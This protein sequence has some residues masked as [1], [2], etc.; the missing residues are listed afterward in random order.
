MLRIAVLGLGSIGR[1]HVRN[2]IA[3]GAGDLLGFD[4][5]AGAAGL[6][7]RE[8][9]IRTVT[10]LDEV[11]AFAPSAVFVTSPSHHHVPLALDA[12]R[13]GCDLFI[14]KPLSDS[15]DAIDQL[16]LAA[17]SQRLVTMVGCNM[18]FHPGPAAV[19]RLIQEGA[20]GAVLSARIH[21]GSYLPDWRPG[22]RYQDSYS[23][24]RE[25]GGGAV[26]DCI[27]EL[28]LALWYSGP[29]TLVASIVRPARSIGLAV[30][31]LAEIL[32]EH[33]NGALSSVHLNYVQRDYL[34]FCQVIGETGTL[35]WYFAAPRVEIRS[36]G[37]PRQ[38][39]WSPDWTADRMF[40]DEAG[41]FLRCV[42]ERTAAPN[43]LAEAERTLR[44]A[45]QARD[46]AVPAQE[47]AR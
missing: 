27:H 11:W 40:V 14:E 15:V 35:H 17:D 36:G 47:P 3:L 33:D 23:A 13:R 24:S 25:Q 18:R 12:A 7:A 34:R 41:E 22:T 39:T 31:G 42:R 5:A 38:V 45:L 1:R 9:G 2:L 46:R 37:A 26:L 32:L 20:I 6:A 21:T 29:A 43:G 28:D 16:R 4:P 19:R 10:N 8:Y 44:L 30:D